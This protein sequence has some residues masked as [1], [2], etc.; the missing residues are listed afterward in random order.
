MQIGDS[1]S[2]NKAVFLG[3]D[4]STELDLLGMIL[5]YFYAN[6]SAAAFS[7]PEGVS[8]KANPSHESS[9][10]TVMSHLLKLFKSWLGYFLV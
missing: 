10:V 4:D 1:G 7:I 3:I 5:Y 8:V 6:P 9:P 2:H